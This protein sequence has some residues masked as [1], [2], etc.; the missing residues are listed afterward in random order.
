MLPRRNAQRLQL[1]GLDVVAHAIEPYLRDE[2]A[3]SGLFQRGVDHIA[4]YTGCL[5][6]ARVKNALEALCKVG[7]EEK[8]P[9]L[10]YDPDT[11][12]GYFPGS[13]AAWPPRTFGELQVRLRM[14]HELPKCAPVELFFAEIAP[15]VARFGNPDAAGQDNQERD[16]KVC[17]DVNDDSAGPKSGADPRTPSSGSAPYQPILDLYAEILPHCPQPEP[18][19]VVPTGTVGKILAEAWRHKSGIKPWKIYFARV[20]SLTKRDSRIPVGGDLC[21]VSLELLLRE[22]VFQEV[23]TLTTAKEAA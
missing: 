12:V 13:C 20:A 16:A 14:A 11:L 22:D 1:R 8:T 19:K 23:K 5:H 9:L 18:W 7:V 15:W 2:A 3:P 10:V 21:L 6:R 17:D 4:S